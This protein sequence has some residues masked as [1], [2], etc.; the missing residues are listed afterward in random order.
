MSLLDDGREELWEE[1]EGL[2]EEELNEKLC[3]DSWSIE[4]VGD[5]LKKME[6]VGGKDVGGEGKKV[7]IK[8]YEGKGVEMGEDG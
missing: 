1:V 3:D 6:V 4:E 8:E 7:A 5:D 2:K